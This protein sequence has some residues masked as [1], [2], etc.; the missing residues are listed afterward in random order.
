MEDRKI[1]DLYF[2]RNEDA[3]RE[4]DRKYGHYCFSV[5]WHILFNNEDSQECVNDT[6]HQTWQLIPPQRPNRLQYFLARIT[7]GFALNRLRT[8]TREKRGG[9]EY[10]AALSE[11]E[12]VLSAGSDPA[13]EFAA[14]ELADVI[15]R[16][17][18]GRKD[19]D[20]NIFVRRY[21]YLESPAEIARRYGLSENNVSVI[22]SRVRTQL[23]EH[24]QKEGYL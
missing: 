18:K 1:L 13:A 4:T 15:N 11:L 22:L 5:A 16:F 20:R 10:D 6:W 24:L 12:G 23:K 9:G 21:F 19:R 14:K 17:L 3:I 2:A 8:K 7:R